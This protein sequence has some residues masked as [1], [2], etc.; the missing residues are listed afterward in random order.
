M[1]V[2]AKL[3]KVLPKN[4][5]CVH[6]VSLG[7]VGKERQL[8]AQFRTV[9]VVDDINDDNEM[10]RYPWAS[11]GSAAEPLITGQ[12]TGRFLSFSSRP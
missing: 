6:M 5:I 3:S 9:L 8:R 10:D 2:T 4:R 11:T 12:R 1:K 7:L